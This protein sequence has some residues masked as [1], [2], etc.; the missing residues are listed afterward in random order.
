MTDP[1]PA[2]GAA[3]PIPITPSPAAATRTAFA[4]ED[5]ASPGHYWS[6]QARMK[7]GTMT[8]GFD[9]D[10]TLALC[11]ARA[12]DADDFRAVYLKE[13]PARIVE[14]ANV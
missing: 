2:R 3:A 8:G 1:L 13:T 6:I 9:P 5:Q 12:Q 11:F 10:R 4:L 7:L 14:L